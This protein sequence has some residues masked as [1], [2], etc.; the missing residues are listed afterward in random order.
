[1]FGYFVAGAA[2][3]LFGGI[4]YKE[5][6]KPTGDKVKEGDTVFVRA[7]GIHLGVPGSPAANAPKQAGLTTLLAGFM[8]TSVKVT[9]V[10]KTQTHDSLLGTI[11][12][13]PDLVGFS[14]TAVTS[15]ER[16]GARIT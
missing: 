14:R 11:V 5:A 16:N 3:L 9:G 10:R 7:D 4:A 1:M 8:S 6:T 15:I 12:G 2:A 13:F